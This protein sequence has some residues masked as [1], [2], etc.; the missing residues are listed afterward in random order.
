MNARVLQ[1]RALDK[2]TF[3]LKSA[4]NII[5][6]SSGWIKTVREAIGLPPHRMPVTVMVET[7]S[8]V[9]YPFC[10]AGAQTGIQMPH[11]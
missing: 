8:A 2:K 7:I 6:Q 10:P 11:S 1:I 4:K 3:D 9:S 5:S